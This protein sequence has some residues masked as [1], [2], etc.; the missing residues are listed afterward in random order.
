MNDI[1]QHIVMISSS[2]N[3]FEDQLLQI[4]S[5][6]TSLGYMVV[7][8]MSGTMKVNPHLHNFDNCMKAVEGCDVFFGI[9]RPDCGTGRL[10]EECVTFQEFKY[11]RELN[12]P[13]WYVIDNKIKTYKTLLKSL[14]L[15]EFPDTNDDDLNTTITSYYDR[16]VRERKCLPR[17]LDIF[18]SKDLR[19]FD[20]V[21]FKME[22]FVNHKG[23]PKENIT[24]NWMQYCN[25]LL[26]IARYIQTNFEDK[27]FIDSIIKE[28]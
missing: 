21:C 5:V 27:D 8:S 17:V 15:R 16:Q 11:A 20:P 1:K 22:D 23:M 3:G 19:Q 28:S 12:K 26:E 4:E 10:D 9:I 25:N 2:V 24:N 14:I 18:E 6:F 7:M 13:C